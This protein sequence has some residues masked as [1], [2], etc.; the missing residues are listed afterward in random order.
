[1]FPRIQAFHHL[2]DYALGT[3]L[4]V[5]PWLFRFSDS[6][7]GVVVTIVFGLALISMSVATADGLLAYRIGWKTHLLGE[8]ILGGFLI[9][10]P[11]IFGFSPHAWVPHVVIGTVV[12][13]RGLLGAAGVTA[14]GL[15]ADDSPEGK[16]RT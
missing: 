3:L 12:A 7:V 1:M 5:G 8:A 6:V 13:A 16:R 4:L 9:G 15:I 14:Y 2:V 10:A 11:W